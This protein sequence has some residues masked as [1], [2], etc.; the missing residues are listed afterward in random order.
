MR[1]IE[2]MLGQRQ[3]QRQYG[4]DELKRHCRT[5]YDSVSHT[6]NCLLRVR[7][8]RLDAAAPQNAVAVVLSF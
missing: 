4:T 5:I 6:V 1:R 7:D 2:R 3:T 8:E